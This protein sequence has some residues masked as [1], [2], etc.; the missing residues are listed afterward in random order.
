MWVM[1]IMMSDKISCNNLVD[2]SPY[3]LLSLGFNLLTVSM[4]EDEYTSGPIQIN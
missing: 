3:P 1:G 4:I 2:I